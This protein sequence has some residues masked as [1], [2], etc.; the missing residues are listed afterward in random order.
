MK[1][2]EYDLKVRKNDYKLINI[3]YP[4]MVTYC[5][6]MEKKP[7]DAKK[8]SDKIIPKLNYNTSGDSKPIEY[9]MLRAFHDQNDKGFNMPQ[10]IRAVSNSNKRGKM[11]FYLG[12]LYDMAGGV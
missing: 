11:W 8:F 9:W 12:L 1:C 3:S 6:F 10:K 7:L 5:Y 2:Y 4:L